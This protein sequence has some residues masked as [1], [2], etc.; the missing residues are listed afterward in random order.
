MQKSTAWKIHD[1][2]RV[3]AQMPARTLNLRTMKLG[4]LP[5][6]PV[7]PICNDRDFG[8]SRRQLR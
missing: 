1:V 7:L 5:T 6:A 2:P 3:V 4:C 8:T